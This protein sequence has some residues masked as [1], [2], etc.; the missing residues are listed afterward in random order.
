[1]RSRNELD[2]SD[3]H[4]LSHLSDQDSLLEP[5]DSDFLTGWTNHKVSILNSHSQ[6]PCI[7]LSKKAE[8]LKCTRKPEQRPNTSTV[9]LST[10]DSAVVKFMTRSGSKDAK[11]PE[12]PR[13]LEDVQIYAP[14]SQYQNIVKL[15]RDNINMNPKI[16]ETQSYRKLAEPYQEKRVK[17]EDNNNKKTVILLKTKLGSTLKDTTHQY[18]KTEFPENLE[19]AT[20][21]LIHPIIRNIVLNPTP[22]CIELSKTHSKSNRRDRQ[23]NS[24]IVFNAANNTSHSRSTRRDTPINSSH[25]TASNVANF[26]T[27]NTAPRRKP[28]NCSFNNVNLNYSRKTFMGMSMFTPRINYTHSRDFCTNNE[29]NTLPPT[30]LNTKLPSPINCNNVFQDMTLEGKD[31]DP[32]ILKHKGQIC[33]LMSTEETLELKKLFLKITRRSARVSRVNFGNDENSSIAICSSGINE[34]KQVN[35]YSKVFGPRGQIV[36]K[37]GIVQRI[38]KDDK[39]LRIYRKFIPKNQRRNQSEDR[40]SKVKDIK[41]IQIIGDRLIATKM[42]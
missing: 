1:M 5:Q 13:V 33:R 24:N 39:D 3:A 8:K 31:S 27:S 25:N 18:L 32:T 7:A 26:I 37:N 42:T 17:D 4:S 36:K 19:N 12:F 11:K 35:Q 2:F 15:D 20:E 40:K 21:G 29:T 6:K 41:T 38:G 10:T 30:L 28:T 22:K 16:F 9:T 23:G 14:Q 34:T